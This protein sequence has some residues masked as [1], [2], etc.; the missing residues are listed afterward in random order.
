[1]NS[2]HT[3]WVGVSSQELAC[4]QSQSVAIIVL[5]HD[6]LGGEILDGSYTCVWYIHVATT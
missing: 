2:Y 6:Q 5:T 1:M 4:M 3:S